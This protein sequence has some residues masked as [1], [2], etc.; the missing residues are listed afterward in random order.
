MNYLKQKGKSIIIV[1]SHSQ[2][3][4]ENEIEWYGLENLIDKCI[5][6]CEDKYRE[7]RTLCEDFEVDPEE[8]PYCGDM[9][10]DIEVAKEAGMISIAVATGY[11]S[12]EN[13]QRKNPDLLAD[14]LEEV[15][16]ELEKC[17]GD[18]RSLKSFSW[19]R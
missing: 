3:N 4:I 16:K 9:D 2:K 17:E 10:N 11:H 5:G 1:S 18:L 7:L 13:L 8:T 19:D 14:D 6:S 15:R 12:K